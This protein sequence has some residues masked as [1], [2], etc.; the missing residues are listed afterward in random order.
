MRAEKP[1]LPPATPRFDTID[2]MRGYS[3]LSV[4]LLHTWLRLYFG[5]FDIR[6][7]ALPHML[8]RFFFSNGGNGVTVF[9]AISGF[10][11]TLTSLRRFGSPS[12]MRIG[13]FYRIRFARIAPLLI[14][15]VVI[16]S[17]LALI[18]AQ[19]FQFSPKKAL[20]WRAVIAVLTFHSNWLE[21]RYGFLPANWNVMWSLSIEEMFYL[22][23][24]IICVTLLRVRRGMFVFVAVLLTFVVMGPFARTVWS[25]NEI[26][27][28]QG[29]LSGMD[30]IALGCITALITHSLE[31]WQAGVSHS[32][33]RRSLRLVQYL[34]WS[35]ILLIALGPN[36]LWKLLPSKPD[37]YGT[38][39]ACA[40]CLIMSASVLR[41]AGGDLE[42]PSM[43]SAPIRWYGK[44]SYEV[45][46]THEFVVVYGVLLFSYFHPNVSP[47]PEGLALHQ[48][49][50]L[51]MSGWI[52]GILALS[53][54]LG[55]AAA[56]F[57]SEPMNRL[58]RGAR[59]PR[60]VIPRLTNSTHLEVG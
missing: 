24:P 48:L 57:I 34:G 17:T 7:H 32:I 35:L 10:L 60:E 12:G 38:L 29:Y 5:G 18:H 13:T 3:I 33:K 36:W 8:A 16:L 59:P 25:T 45:Y 53:A 28:E 30:C 19:G 37:C 11:I 2:T 40:A 20:L 15:V 49:S 46:L 56:H 41:Q 14:S 54:P 6:R 55:W 52:L 58:L 4:V 23:F 31:A 47:G 42:R 9:F 26:W 22:F 43:L 27:S 51:Q 1:S 50:V 39:L 21:A 44:H